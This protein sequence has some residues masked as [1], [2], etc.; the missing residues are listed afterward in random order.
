MNYTKGCELDTDADGVANSKDLCPNTPAAATVDNTGCRPDGDK[1]GVVDVADL[2]PNTE[3]GEEVDATGCRKAAPIVLSGVNFIS[4]SAELTEPAKAILDTVAASIAEHPAL[5]L[6][7]AG[8]TDDQGPAAFNEALSQ[9]RA[10][11]VRAY[12]IG[13]GA[14]E[15][16]LSAKGYGEAKP[17][18]D[19]ATPA[20]RAQNR[21]V[22]LNRS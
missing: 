17:I 11:A 12:L 4:G 10:E 15:D 5:K 1:D 22:E 18:A 9:Q 20:G 2:C 13:K 6:E 19:N 7:V 14:I 3:A 21:R 8:H 16:N